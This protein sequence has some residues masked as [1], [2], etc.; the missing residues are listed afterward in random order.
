LNGYPAVKA[1][2]LL[3]VPSGIRAFSG[4]EDNP[5]RDPV[6]RTH[7]NPIRLPFIR[8]FRLTGSRWATRLPGFRRGL[9]ILSGPGSPQVPLYF[10]D[11]LNVSRIW[12][13]DALLFRCRLQA[14]DLSG[15]GGLVRL[16]FPG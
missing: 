3:V 9:L 11:A 14:P 5:F 4:L 7:G 1:D 6:C 12:T 2:A 10:N 8:T 15:Y 16:K 13:A